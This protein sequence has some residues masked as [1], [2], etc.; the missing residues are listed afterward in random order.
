MDTTIKSLPYERQGFSQNCETGIIEYM[1]AGIDKPK[2]TFVEIGFGDGTQNMTLDLLHLGYSGVGI[3]GWDWHPTVTE[4]W[5]DQLI[6]IKQMIAPENVAQYIPEPYW[7]PDFFSL[8]IDSFDYEVAAVLL[9]SGFRPA[10]ACCEINKHFGEDWAS[11]PYVKDAVKFTYNR[12]FLYGCSLPKYKD[13]WAQYGYEFF[14]FDTRAVNAFWFHPEHASIDVEVLRHQDLT[15]IDST[16][17]RS[18]IA[19]H[20]LWKDKQDIIYQKP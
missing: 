18:H 14:T 4:R 9:E 10:V 2:K 13:L 3:D 17:I 8:D 19:D 12:Q 11:F 1:L 15:V 7:Q 6:K 20:C 5:P 16:L